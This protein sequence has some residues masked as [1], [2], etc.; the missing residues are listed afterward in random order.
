MYLSSRYCGTACLY[1]VY[2]GPGF[3]NSIN[4]MVL[5]GVCHGILKLEIYQWYSLYITLGIFVRGGG[6]QGWVERQEP[7]E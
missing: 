7:V 4:C 2:Y 6:P 1:V 5:L 3:V